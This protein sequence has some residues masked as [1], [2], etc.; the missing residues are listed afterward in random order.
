MARTYAKFAGASYCL[1]DSMVR[2]WTCLGHC[3]GGTEG[4]EV[5][6]LST[7]SLT[8]IKYYVGVNHRLKAIILS[9]RGTLTPVNAIVDFSWVPLGMSDFPGIPKGTMA[10][11][12]FL[13]AALRIAGVTQ[14]KL[15]ELATK[16]P[17][18]TVDFT[19][20]SLG[21][22]TAQLVALHFASSTSVPPSRVRIIT[23]GAPRVGNPLFAK[24]IGS[25]GFKM[26]ARVTF[27]NDPVP[28]LPP[29]NT[30]WLGWTVGRVRDMLGFK[31]RVTECQ[32]SKCEDPNCANSRVPYLNLLMHL[33]AY[34]ITFGPWC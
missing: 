23:Y 15:L 7:D 10:H 28:H 18:Y 30:G 25:A 32:D 17:D 29:S 1:V 2:S 20:H 33:R 27:N 12:G 31:P 14:Q 19:G 8:E 21:G 3:S 13:V 26:L 16:Y 11:A 4:T 6:M 5:A 34:D 22:A 9:I 24:V